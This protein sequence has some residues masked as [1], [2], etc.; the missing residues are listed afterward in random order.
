LAVKYI[1]PFVAWGCNYKDVDHRGEGK[2]GG[3]IDRGDRV[4]GCVIICSKGKGKGGGYSW[5]GLDKTLRFIKAG[6]TDTDN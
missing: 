5:E 2:G 1:W 3:I 6:K 4:G